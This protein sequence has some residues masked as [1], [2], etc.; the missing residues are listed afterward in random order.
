MK[1]VMSFFVF[2]ICG[3]CLFAQGRIGINTTTPQAILHV[4]D[5]SVLFSGGA[6]PAIPG[7]PPASGSG[8]R[9]MWYPA[10]AAFRSGDPAGNNWDKDSI[11]NYSFA[12]G[13]TTRAKGE[14]SFAAG[15]NANAI[16]DY[17]FALGRQVTSSGVASTTFGYG[18]QSLGLASFV[19]NYFNTAN[20]PY[21][22]AL[23][24]STTSSGQM[25]FSTG[26]DTE[27][28]GIVSIAG[29]YRAESVGSYSLSVGFQSY[30]KPF[31]SF[32]IGR[33]NNDS[34]GDSDT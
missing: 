6:L 10:K 13:G 23:G 16:G 24:F 20:A 29:G 34:I 22:A 12:V 19:A 1:S 15:F 21:S 2:I 14:Y 11:G 26:Y 18:G 32:V 33:Y 25:A 8:I 27:A 31:A 4:K 17:S 9:L 3:H 5:S 30:A 28:S 7:N